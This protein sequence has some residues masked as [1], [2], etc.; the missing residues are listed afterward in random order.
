MPVVM[1]EEADKLHTLVLKWQKCALN[2]VTVS[3]AGHLVHYL[4]SI[5]SCIS[6]IGADDCASRELCGR[7]DE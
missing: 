4:R 3:A 7:R 2:L 5:A 6:D 1:P